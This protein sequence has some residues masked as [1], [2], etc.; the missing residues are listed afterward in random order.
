MAEAAGEFFRVGKIQHLVGGMRVRVWTADAKRNYLRPWIDTLELLEEGNRAALTVAGSRLVKECSTC[1]IDGL[2]K[3]SLQLLLTPPVA[4]SPNR[5]GDFGVVW[6]VCREFLD[7][8][9]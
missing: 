5:G 9:S 2:C 6:D 7:H 1:L 3:P 8:H 4:S